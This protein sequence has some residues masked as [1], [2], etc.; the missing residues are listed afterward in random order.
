[1]ATLAGS[2]NVLPN[3][4]ILYISFMLPITDVIA[5]RDASYLSIP[6]LQSRIKPSR[7][8]QSRG[9]FVGTENLFNVME[10]HNAVLSGSRALEYF[11][12]GSTGTF[13][14]WDFYVPSTPSS[15][16]AVKTALEHSGVE[17]QTCL[18]RAA[19]I[20]RK[21]S[22]A[23]LSRGHIVSI[24]YEAYYSQ[25]TFWSKEHILIVECIL[26]RYPML[27]DISVHL[28]LNGSI[29][30]IEGILPLLIPRDGA[31]SVAQ[32]ME[33]DLDNYSGRL[34]AKVI[35]GVAWKRGKEVPV[36]LI[37]G[38]IDP[39]KDFT[40]DHF[41]PTVFKSIFAFYASHVQCILAKDA[42]PHMYYTL[43]LNKRAYRWFVPEIIQNKAEAAVQKYILRGYQFIK[44]KTKS[45]L[46]S[47]QDEEACYID[48]SGSS[49]TCVQQIK[50]LRWHHNGEDIKQLPRIE[51]VLAPELV[52]FGLLN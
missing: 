12:P 15:V 9:P 29:R 48:F 32:S 52:Y 39:R 26:K 36:Q 42:A 44:A 11:I 50:G 5:L 45:N 33:N 30:W 31:T 49:T 28:R 14:D 8:L 7:Y 27:S 2:F 4:L 41:P 20:M 43:A 22:A 46:R 17:F 25:H 6:I 38:K 1:M 37:V 10:T 21:E 16:A 40:S 35:H 3:E 51:K 18:S 24:A 47:A 23:I 13:S 19:N 34:A